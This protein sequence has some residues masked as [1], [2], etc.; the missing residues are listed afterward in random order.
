MATMNEILDTVHG[1]PLW[2]SENFFFFPVNFPTPTSVWTERFIARSL[3]F[4][5][6]FFFFWYYLVSSL[7]LFTMF[8]IKEKLSL[9]FFF[10]Y[11]FSTF[12][13]PPSIMVVRYFNLVSKLFEIFG[14]CCSWFR[15]GFHEVIYFR[16][17]VQHEQNNL[18]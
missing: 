8:S 16:F 7:G 14:N 12:F 6:N 10:F 15:N 18:R 1:Q 9:I 3:N 5:D 2:L 13:P 11:F 4:R 17:C